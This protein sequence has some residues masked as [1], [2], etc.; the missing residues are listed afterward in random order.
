MSLNVNSLRALVM[1]AAVWLAPCYNSI[2][3]ALAEDGAPLGVQGLSQ[4]EVGAIRRT[5]LSWTDALAARDL[6]LWDR[7]WAKDSMLMPPGGGRITGVSGLN[8][9]AKTPP[10]D[11][12]KK[13]TFSDWAIAGR[14]DLAVV[15]NNI[16]VEPQSGGAPAIFKQ[17]IVMR[18]HKNGK[19]LIQ[20][21]MFNSLHSSH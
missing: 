15:S 11:D 21:V 20:A 13:A 14:D 5:I 9:V 19:W 4:T 7:Y 18:R 16:A 10:Y 8:A 17:L 12:I 2:G 6:T 1:G 3:K